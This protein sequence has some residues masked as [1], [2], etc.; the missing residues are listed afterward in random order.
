M[1]MNSRVILIDPAGLRIFTACKLVFTRGSDDEQAG[2]GVPAG[3]VQ[4]LVDE[5]GV[6]EDW[7]V[8]FDGRPYSVASVMP[9]IARRIPRRFVLVCT[10]EG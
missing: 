8:E 9:Y 3:Q 2:V 7:S 6:T 1:K 5:S 10:P 4:L